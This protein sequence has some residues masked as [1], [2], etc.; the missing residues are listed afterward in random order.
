MPETDA[1]LKFIEEIYDAAL[2]PEMWPGTLERIGDAFNGATLAL[3]VSSEASSGGFAASARADPSLFEL[4]MSDYVTPERNPGI[5][6]LMEARPGTIIRRESI[7]GDSAF[8][9]SDF[10]NAIF[11]PHVLWHWMFG[12]ILAEPPHVAVFGIS[13]RPSAGEFDEREFKTLLR[14]V[15]H[16][17]RGL[18][19]SLRLQRL[20][21]RRC[22]LEGVLAYLPMG[23]AILDA[24]GKVLFLNP[25]AEDIIASEDA[26]GVKDR[27]LVAADSAEANNLSR[28][29]GK[30]AATGNGVGA[31][32]GDAMTLSRRSGSRPLQVLVVP[33]RLGDQAHWAKGSATA[34]FISDPERSPATPTSLLRQLYGLT[35]KEAE[36]AL[37]V[38]RGHELKQVADQLHMTFE[39]ARGHM[40]L[41]LDKTG[42]H[43]QV[44]LVRDLLR[45]PAGLTF[46]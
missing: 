45:S 26:L 16:L 37:M 24:K 28:L 5:A 13:R 18:Q 12:P 9:A 27:Q 32:P 21:H 35:P 44:E 8:R 39:T 25:L 29:I 38:M 3:H 46:R 36:I 17:Q 22:E 19:I 40:K 14:L 34:V 10:Y 33:L 31:S 2:R 42:N 1:R 23:V 15:P 11:R 20:N 41:I 4:Y 30:A 6:P 43:R 7:L